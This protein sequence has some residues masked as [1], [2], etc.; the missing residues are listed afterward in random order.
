MSVWAEAG[1][2]SVEEGDLR[3]GGE[4]GQRAGPPEHRFAHEPVPVDGEVQRLPCPFVREREPFGVAVDHPGDGAHR[5][6]RDEPGVHGALD[7]PGVGGRDL[8]QDVDL[9]LGRADKI[10][11]PLRRNVVAEND[12]T[13]ARSAHFVPVARVRREAHGGG[14]ILAPQPRAGQRLAADGCFIVVERG[15]PFG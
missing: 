14:A 9:A 4:P 3:R 11:R 1:G 7:A 8:R 13:Q 12:L 5:V 15:V 6:D 10:E 2:E